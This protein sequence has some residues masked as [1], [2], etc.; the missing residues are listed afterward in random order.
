[1]DA[2]GEVHTKD[3]SPFSLREPCPLSPWGPHVA[4]LAPRLSEASLGVSLLL[5]GSDRLRE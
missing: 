2:L 5:G 4:A 3:G 1:M